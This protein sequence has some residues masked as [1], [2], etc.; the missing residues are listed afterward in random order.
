MAEELI[1]LVP[2]HSIEAEACV[3]GSMLLD[4]EAIT[5]VVQLL[6]KESFYRADHQ[7]IFDAIISLYDANQAVDIVLLRE[8]LQKDGSADIDVDLL[9]SLVESVPSA[10]NA[11]YYSRIVQQKA[12]VRKLITSCNSTVRQCYETGV[13]ADVLLDHA[14]Q[15]LFEVTK[16]RGGRE[17][18]KL[19]EILKSVFDMIDNMEEN[20]LTGRSTKYSELDNLTSGLHD[21]ELIIIAGRP[22]MGKTTFALNLLLNVS[23]EEKVP[24]ALFSL[25]MAAEQIVQNILCSYSRVSM[26]KMRRGFLNKE[27]RTRLVQGAAKLNDIPIYVD[28]SPGLSILELRA[29][30]RRMKSQFDIQMLVI[31]YLQLMEGRQSRNSEN[32]QQEISDISRG[33][34]S[35]ARELEIPV[36]ALSQLSRAVESREGNKPRMSDLRESGSIEQDADVIMLLYREDYYNPDRREGE[37]D[38]IIAKQRNGPTGTV[39]FAFLG[40]YLR[41][42]TYAREM[43]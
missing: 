30:A 14:E 34:K 33:L 6:D 13:D 35:L 16:R 4:R 41:F 21:S 39:T 23:I 29:K 1:A 17:S 42:E 3:L 22:S 8:E 24:V 18:A 10:A 25:E 19:G 7:R 26:Q 36:I 15:S 11:E 12:L 5:Q 32:R 28:D 38:I 43:P 9:A 2:P 40:E 37:A 31:D 20:R 27:E